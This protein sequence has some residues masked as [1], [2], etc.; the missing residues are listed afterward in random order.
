MQVVVA[1][2]CIG[3]ASGSGRRFAGEGLADGLLARGGERRKEKEESR[4]KTEDRG[5]RTE[6]EERRKENGAQALA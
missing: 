6:K 3:E 5:Q 4:E 2:G 1:F